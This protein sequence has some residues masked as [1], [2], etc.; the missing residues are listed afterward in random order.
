VQAR[1]KLQD[2]SKSYLKKLENF[3]EKKIHSDFR[4]S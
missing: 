3:I 4:K 1:K 2:L